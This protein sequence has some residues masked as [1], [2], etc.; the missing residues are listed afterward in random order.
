M[1]MILFKK[2]AA[3]IIARIFGGLG[4][5]LFYAAARPVWRWL[6]MLSGLLMS[7]YLSKIRGSSCK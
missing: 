7:L 5:Q 4:N 1:N 2:T 6:T 3:K